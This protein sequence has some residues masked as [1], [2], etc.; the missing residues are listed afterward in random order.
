MIKNIY[1]IFFF[2]LFIKENLKKS[3]DLIVILEIFRVIY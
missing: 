1:Y 3:K 2:T